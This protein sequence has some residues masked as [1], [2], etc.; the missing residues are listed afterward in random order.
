MSLNRL[1][2]FVPFASPPDPQS[3]DSDRPASS[4]VFM[5]SF[6]FNLLAAV[7]GLM[8]LVSAAALIVFALFYERCV[9]GP[10]RRGGALCCQMGGAFVLA[11][12]VLVESDVAFRGM[13]PEPV[14][15]HVRNSKPSFPE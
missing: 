6:S 10:L 1:P 15:R 14:F 8:L 12:P 2:S 13:D 3:Q 5:I 7:W 11:V 9:A 4:G